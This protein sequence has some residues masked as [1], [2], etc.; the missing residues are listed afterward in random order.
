MAGGWLRHIVLVAWIS[1]TMSDGP[2]STTSVVNSIPTPTPTTSVVNSIPTPT[3]I[4]TSNTPPTP[5]ATSSGTIAAFQCQEEG[6]R[7]SSYK[8]NTDWKY[9]SQSA[10]SF[11]DCQRGCLSTSG[12]TGIEFD[13]GDYCALWLNN[14][15]R[16]VTGGNDHLGWHTWDKGVT[17]EKNC[18]PST[19]S[20]CQ[21]FTSTTGTIVSGAVNSATCTYVKLMTIAGLLV[22]CFTS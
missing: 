20:N 13:P 15:C 17:C 2:L 21:V 18:D 4:P 12:C 9:Y 19:S 5:V 22:R 7:W 3:P 10:I 8:A 16:L 11:A 1:E 6:C 14:K